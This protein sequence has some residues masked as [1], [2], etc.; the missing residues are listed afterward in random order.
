MDSTD[1]T[2]DEYDLYVRKRLAEN[3]RMNEWTSV[4]DSLPPER[5]FVLVFFKQKAATWL[6][7]CN[8]MYYSN[9]DWWYAGGFNSER[10]DSIVSHWTQLTSPIGVEPTVVVSR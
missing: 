7:D 5:E 6:P 9:G 8:I 1:S 4:A 3:L 2:K 10:M